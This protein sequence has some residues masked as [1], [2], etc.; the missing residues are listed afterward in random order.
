MS[1]KI[2]VRLF[3]FR[4]YNE[5]LSEDSDSEEEKKS[6]GDKKETVIQMYGMN[7]GGETFAIN[8][9]NFKPFFYVKVP[10]FWDLRN[11]QN[12]KEKVKK[13]IGPYYSESVK[14][15]KYINKKKLYG[16]DNNKTYN[17]IKI[18]FNNTS[19]F[20]KVKGL[21][22]TK[23]EDFRKRYLIKN[24]FL[25][26]K[27]YEAKLPPLLRF[28]HI[29]DIS[30]SGWVSF[31]EVD[32]DSE[33]S[34]TC[35]D[36]EYWIDYDNIT[37]EK[38]KEDSIPLKI[39]SF[40]IEASSSHGDFPLAKKTYLK[41]CRQMVNY[42]T[43]NKK[44]IRNKSLEEKHTLFTELIYTA[45]EY[46]NIEGID[47]I[48]LKKNRE[49]NNVINPKQSL[50]KYLISN[51]LKQ[52]LWFYLKKM[53]EDREEE[54]IEET[55]RREE[56]LL[57]LE[58][59][60]IFTKKKKK[61]RIYFKNKEFYKN[62][63]LY[64]LN[65]KEEPTLIADMLELMFKKENFPRVE[66]DT[67]T[68][69]G[70]TFMRLGEQ[71]QYL[72]NMIVLNSCSSC[73]EVSNCEIETY[74][75]ERDVLLA[76]TKMIQR[77]D[78]DIVI[79]YNI[80]GF[81]YKFMIARAEELRCKKDFLK[82][83]R[84]VGEQSRVID[85][86]IKIASGTHDLR[87]IKMEGRVQIDLYNHFRREINLPSYK[88]DNVA[89][90]F[91]GDIIKDINNIDEKTIIKS[92]NLMG[93]KDGHYICFEI[94]GHSTDKYKQGKKFIV[95]QMTPD[96]FIVNCKEVA[97]DLKDKK[98]RWCLAKD[99]VTPQDI[100]RLTNEGPDERAIIAKYCF[101]DCNLV[102]NLMM[103]NDIFTGM[104]EIANI[105]YVPVEFI[106]MRGQGI[107]LLSFIAKKCSE[108][109]TLMPVLDVEKGDSSYEGAICLK[110]YCGLYIDNPVAV[111]DYASLYPSSM[112]S[113][114][115][116][117]DSKVWTKEYDLKGNIER[118]SMGNEMIRGERDENGAFKYDNLPEYKYV[119]ITYDRYIWRRKGK[120][121]AQEKIKVGTKTCRF[122]Q[123][124]GGKKAIMPSVLHELLAGR[125]ATR[126][127]IKYKTVT[128][129]DGEEISGLY[130]VKDKICT[131]VSEK[132]ECEFD[133]EDVVSVRDTYDDFM[134]NVFDKRQQG[135]KVT[136][137]SLYG[138]TGARTSSFYEMDI[139]A[140]TTAT[141]RKLLIY[142]KKIIEGIYGNKICE[143]THGKIRCKSKVIYGDSVTG[144]EPLILQDENKKVVIKTI[145]SLSNDWVEYE[146]FKPFD[147]IESNRREKQKAFV[148][149]KVWANGKW[150]PIKK[151]IR[152]K[153]NKNIYRVNTHVG[154]VD[155]TGDHSLVNDNFEKIKPTDCV[156]NKTKLSH[157]FPDEFIENECIVLKQG[158]KEELDENLYTCSTCQEKYDKT[159]YYMD[160]KRRGKRCKLCIKKKTCERKGEKFNGK[161]EKKIINIYTESYSITEDEARVWGMFMGD[162]SC[163]KYKNGKRNVKRNNNK[164][165][166]K[167]SWAINNATIERLNV[168]KE[169]LEKI[170][171]IKFKILN[172]IKSSGVYKLVP[173][174]NIVYI[175]NKYRKL[176]YS[177]KKEKIVP[178][179]ILNAKLSIRKAYFEGYYDADGS[180]THGCGIN[181]RMSF[182]AKNKITA[183]CL[184]YLATS[185]GYNNLSI[186]YKTK[187]ENDYYTISS[188]K[189]WGKEPTMLKKMEII[190]NSGEEYVYDLETEDGIFACGVGKLQLFNTD[191]CFLT[192]NAEE[193]DGKKITGKKALDI[194]IQLAIECG[195]L[196]SKFLKPPHDLEYEKTFD[197]FLLLSKK[198]YVGM[199]YEHDINK[200]KRK[201]M[202][203]VLKR[204]DNAPVVK[205][206]YGGIIDIIMKERN[207]EKAVLFLKTFLK[208]I[209][210]EKI[211]LDKLIITKSL[212]EFYKCPESIAHKVLAD[213][214]GKRDPGNKPSTGS[215]IPFVFI[216]TK[217]KVKLQGEKIEHPDY[218]KEHGLKPDYKI[219]ITN[220]I[221][222]PVMQIFALVLENLKVFKTRKRGFERKIRS[223]ERKWK[224]DDKKCVENIMKVRNKHV[225]ELLFD[226]I[227][228]VYTNKQNGQQTI[229]SLFG[230]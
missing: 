76:W 183:Q 64:L 179:C 186:N 156:V 167:F 164:T 67:V 27:L 215:R 9:M 79:G 147:T 45:F 69:I 37:S 153:T 207:I 134:K 192:F 210:D 194:T 4:I 145:E 150:N 17:F 70:S 229:T 200:C 198:R 1:E 96:S 172:T 36:Y 51:M 180:K 84:L 204:R 93:L 195:E 106:V 113:E 94:L 230:I 7:E 117:H 131:I 139:A 170:E 54:T 48:Y 104:S 62:D 177:E 18:T 105:C 43:T 95:E 227:L 57:L 80:F 127:F 66:G 100:F 58:D 129:S 160:K 73:P 92:K 26:T 107:K 136:A 120:G 32:I 98:C 59:E 97:K 77:E 161:L 13:E 20:N 132:E 185:I 11:L 228:R 222:K 212:R 142:G 130:S 221:M 182:L 101:Q 154:V 68:F 220:Q 191:S 103:K 65:S 71:D 146:N 197:P 125:K 168:Y 188:C 99:D 118:D 218:I 44:T 149:Y 35:C 28:F 174:G 30:P 208:D 31:K 163:G 33:S 2:Y 141:G 60:D 193:L 181:K 173:I 175:V 102:H 52:N 29:N 123:F 169:I 199:L 158:I 91:I 5:D 53:K 42:W 88:L 55:Q 211:P 74:D 111:V 72:N 112:I 196:A 187:N 3:D 63:I 116:S 124:P 128:L 165:G 14:K 22:Y 224:D 159:F 16:F 126:K 109:N 85:S 81:D 115:I 223:L 46:G 114:N 190:R 155:V 219:Y 47:K 40:D 206:V 6:F 201:S 12:F 151:V 50:L 83:G 133:E 39:C 25:R 213:R 225:K 24:G 90:H 217:K 138:Q 61:K 75:N 8:V 226:D 34:E 178:N 56:E 148:K 38:K 108:K 216:K 137:N 87:Y 162:G 19:A 82:L 122:A 144:N 21:W 166:N 214:M 140:S 209:I 121:K 157:T 10:Q 23:D 205:D 135:L 176:F 86:S 49:A 184:Y 203:I 78:P 171:P 152:H 41:L 15:F 189:K 119:D 143:T 110:P 202:G 89:S